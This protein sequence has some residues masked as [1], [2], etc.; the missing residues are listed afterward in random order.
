[1]RLIFLVTRADTIAGSQV[2]I[3]ELAKMLQTDGHE[4]LVVTGA[5]GLF[6]ETLHQL[7]IPTLACDS[8]QRAIHPLKDW[9][10]GVAELRYERINL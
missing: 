9:Q 7:K 1:M 2:H 3:L 5:Q 8:L 4:I 6:T 10:A